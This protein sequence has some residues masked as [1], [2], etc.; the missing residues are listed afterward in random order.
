MTYKYSPTTQCD[1]KHKFVTK[2]IADSTFTR[3]HGEAMES[4]KCPF[5]SFWHIGHIDRTQKLRRVKK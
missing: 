5:C 1:G 3:K 2:N 4:Y